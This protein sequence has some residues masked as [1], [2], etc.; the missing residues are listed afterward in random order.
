MT[1]PRVAPDG[2]GDSCPTCG[3]AIIPIVYGIAPCRF[4]EEERG[5]IALGGCC[6]TGA[7]PQFRVPRSGSATTGGREL[8][9]KCQACYSQSIF[10][11]MLVA[12]A[13]LL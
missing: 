6:I 7:A 3:A 2:E 12:T 4:E 10:G 1:A 8:V 11:A 9:E 5:Q 13:T